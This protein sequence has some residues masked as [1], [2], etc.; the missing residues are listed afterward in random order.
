LI[1]LAALAF[2]RKPSKPT[3][4]TQPSAN[5]IY[6]SKCGNQNASTNQFCRKCGTKLG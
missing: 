2:R 3:P 6:C 5:V 4:V 1:L